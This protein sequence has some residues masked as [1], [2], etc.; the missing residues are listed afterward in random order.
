MISEAN[1]SEYVRRIAS[2]VSS[3]PLG[4]AWHRPSPTASFR[5][6]FQ[7]VRD[8]VKL[9]G[10]VSKY[11][12]TFTVHSRPPVGDYLVL[13]HHAMWHAPDGHLT[14]ITPYPDPKYR[15]LGPEGSILF[16]VDER[17]LPVGVPLAL[18]PLPLKFF[19]LSDDP[20][21]AQYVAKLGDDEQAKCAELYAGLP[22][23]STPDSQPKT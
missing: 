3:G 13:T 23:P 5:H 20:A 12:W 22:N 7:N 1:L 21:L 19:A 15:P 2:G 9:G 14:D 17:A 10:G 4:L 8:Q 6:C 18:A 16:L 11:G